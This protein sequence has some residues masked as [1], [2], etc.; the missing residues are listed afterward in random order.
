MCNYLD[1]KLKSSLIGTCRYCQYNFCNRHRL[2][3]THDCINL[4]ISNFN[5]TVVLNDKLISE[6]IVSKKIDKL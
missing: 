4:K 2:Q 1:C 5:L 3:E 6:K